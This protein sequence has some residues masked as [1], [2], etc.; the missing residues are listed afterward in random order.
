MR[1][2]VGFAC[3]YKLMGRTAMN[4]PSVGLRAVLGSGENTLAAS[5]RARGKLA[6][7][8]ISLMSFRWW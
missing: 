1:K 8:T 3:I 2:V 7:Y 5:K 6:S 4:T